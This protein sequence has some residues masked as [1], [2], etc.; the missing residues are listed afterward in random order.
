MDDRYGKF[1]KALTN[2]YERYLAVN[3]F[4]TEVGVDFIVLLFVSKRVLY[5]LF[6]PK[7][8]FN[9]SNFMSNVFLS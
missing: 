1:Y 2:D 3:H 6:E 5:D 4:K 7:K 9:K 8:K